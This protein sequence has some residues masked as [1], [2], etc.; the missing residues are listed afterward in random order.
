M[1]ALR[2][3]HRDL[4][5]SYAPGFFPCMEALKKRPDSVSRVLV[6]SKAESSDILPELLALCRERSIRVE[7]ADR[8]LA[9][10]S[11]K[12]NVFAAA[13]FAKQEHPLQKDS[14]H[15]VL[16]HPGDKGNLG[17]IL[18]TALGFQFLNMAVILPAADLHDPQ[19]VRASMGALFSMRV[20]S[21]TCFE[22][23]HAA[24]PEHALYPFMLQASIPLDEA[25]ANAVSPFA[26][27]MGN[28]GAGLPA[29]YLTLGQ[30]VRIP[31]NPAIDS[32]NLAV[33]ASIGM[34]AF[35]KKHNI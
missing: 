24:Y 29:E 16:Y 32:L 14:N 26:L 10:I 31:H 33:A 13:V 5:Y 7:T 34:Y 15:L 23:Y 18:R 25:A 8:A 12:D 19:V 28:E 4:S 1:P 6:H 17:T 21:F 22:D 11:Q 20:Q 35:S 27:I 9:R 2:P 30:P 3:Y